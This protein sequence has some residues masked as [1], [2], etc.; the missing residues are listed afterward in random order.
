MHRSV[1]TTVTSDNELNEQEDR[2]LRD[3]VEE[4]QK[5]GVA[6]VLADPNSGWLRDEDDS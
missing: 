1:S 6:D 3:A 5:D 2:R 4:I